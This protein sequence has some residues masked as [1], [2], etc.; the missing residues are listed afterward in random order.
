M[1]MQGLLIF[2]MDG[3]LVDVTGS[4][5]QTV[6]QTVKHFTGI[7]V[8]NQDIQA[9]KNRGGS[10][11]DWDLAVEMICAN[12]GSPDRD[13]VIAA[14]RRIYLGENC[15]GLISQE[16][17]LAGDG[18][19]ARL[20]ERW[21]LALFTGRERW[22]ALHTLAKFAPQAVFDPV[23]GMEDVAREKP[24]PDGLFKIL[25]ATEP[26]EAYYI[27]D[28]MDDCR[29]ALAARV[30]FIGVA[31]PENPLREDLRARFQQEGA[32]AVV[33]DLSELERTLP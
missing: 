4:Y 28:T 24:D 25:R 20:A 7:E 16:R 1:I 18:L 8:T 23:I 30:A 15:N 32:F 9:L 11:N 6:I 31:G 13:E 22:E 27:G 33:S 5:R 12:G 19:L 26:G 29:A 10:N 2:D 14:F 17:W 3:V 21:R